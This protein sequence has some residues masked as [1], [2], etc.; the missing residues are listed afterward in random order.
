[1]WVVIILLSYILGPYSERWSFRKDRGIFPAPSTGFV[2]PPFPPFISVPLSASLAAALVP[3]A[4]SSRSAPRPS[5]RPNPLKQGVGGVGG[6]KIKGGG[7]ADI[8]YCDWAK[9]GKDKKCLHKMIIFPTQKFAAEETISKTYLNIT[10]ERSHSSIMS[11]AAVKHRP[12][13]P[14]PPSISL[15]V[16]KFLSATADFSGFGFPQKL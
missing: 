9:T 15:C 5:Y 8:V 2:A 4:Y 13:S 14:T 16:S 7:G 6:T 3:L 12:P 1:M 11:L 10:D